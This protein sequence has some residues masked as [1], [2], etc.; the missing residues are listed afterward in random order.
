M[1]SPG[2]TPG[3]THRLRHYIIM[4][5]V[6]ILGLFILLLF[7]NKSD[8]FG[9]TSAV[10]EN[11]KNSSLIGSIGYARQEITDAPFQEAERIVPSTNDIEFLLVSS[12]IPRMAKETRIEH[13]KISFSDISTPITVNSD[14]LE[15]NGLSQVTIDLSS[16]TGKIEFDPSQ[17]SLD[18]IAK[19]FEVNGIS[20]SSPN[21]IKISFKGLNYQKMEITN[22]EFR[23]LEFVGGEGYV[24]VGDRLRYGLENG[25]TITIYSYFGDFNINKARAALELNSTFEDTNTRIQG[26]A[27]GLDVINGALSLN[28]R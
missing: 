14:K 19:K 24:Q 11:V 5:T 4:T 8:S 25:Q 1:S 18:G 15:L 9:I 12:A 7:N 26:F 13:L 3:P 16:F 21:E 2:P 28:L 10:I 23:D 6:V 22:A 17:I 20:L 27:K